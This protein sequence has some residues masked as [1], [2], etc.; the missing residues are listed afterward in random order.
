MALAYKPVL[1][2]QTAPWSWQSLSPSPL[3]LLTLDPPPPA[4]GARD[5]GA[6]EL[7]Q[8]IM[9]SPQNTLVLA[10]GET[11]LLQELGQ[12]ELSGVTQRPLWVL[13]VLDIWYQSI[14]TCRMC[15]LDHKYI[16]WD[17]FFF[18]PCVCC[19]FR[20]GSHCIASQLALPLKAE[21]ENR[22]NKSHPSHSCKTWIMNTCCG[23]QVLL[24]RFFSFGFKG[25]AISTLVR[26]LWTPG[27]GE[28][29]SGQQRP[30]PAPCQMCIPL[31]SAPPT[32]ARAVFS[33]VEV[34]A[35]NF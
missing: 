24:A 33:Q 20:R 23:M 34:R 1:L 32:S 29:L 16:I 35:A 15:I 10:R 2:D 30:A 21:C 18:F 6:S 17:F 7:E 4:N 13:W 28:E 3:V 11:W 25:E 22:G 27:A 26:S 31:P 5:A 8:N 12:P 9:S 14:I 19:V